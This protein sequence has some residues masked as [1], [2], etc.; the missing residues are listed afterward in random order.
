[1]FFFGANRWG[2]RVELPAHDQDF[3]DVKDV[4]H[5][6]AARD[7]FLLKEHRLLTPR[8]RYTPPGDEGS[9]RA[10]TVVYLPSMVGVRTNTRGASKAL[11]IMDNLIAE[12][13]TKPFI[14]VMT[15]A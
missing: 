1:M 3:Y 12:G 11:V 2:S 13:K 14:I 9:E 8:V 10:L 6:F 15:T 4:P 5:G 7:S